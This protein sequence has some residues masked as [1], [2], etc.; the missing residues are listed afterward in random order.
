M[1]KYFKS[2]RPLIM[3]QNGAVA[4]NHPQA[5]LVGMDVLRS[6]GNAADAAVAVSLALGVV[7]PCMSGLGGDGFYHVWNAKKKHSTVFNGTGPAPKNSSK[8]DF[9]KT[10]V[11]VEG[12]LSI[13]TPGMVGG[14]SAMHRAEGT[15]SWRKV[16]QPAAN[17]A[18][19][20]FFATHAYR[21]FVSASQKKLERDPTSRNIFLENDEIP[22]LGNRVIQ[23]KLAMTLSSLAVEGAEGFYRGNLAKN[24]AEDMR[25]AKLIVTGDDLSSFQPQIQDSISINYRG[26][27]IKQTPPNSTGFT[28]LQ[29]LKI[30]EQFDLSNI[31]FES[32]ELIHL[33]VEAKKQAFFDRERFGSDPLYVDIP[34]DEL[35]SNSY[36]SE[37]AK[38]ICLEKSTTVPLAEIN[39][40]NGDTTYFCI[41]DRE[42]NAVSA[43]QSIN[44]VFGSGIT[45]SKTG[46]LFNNR[47][48]YWHLDEAHNNVLL[49]GKR[50]RHTMNAPIVLRDGNLW[51]VFGTPGADN[52]VQVNF[53]IAVAMMDYGLDPQQAVEAARWSSSQ[54]GQGANWPHNGDNSLTIE[55]GLPASTVPNLQ[56][57]G[58]KIQLIEKLDGPCSVACI[59]MLKNNTLIAGSDPRRDGWAG[60]Y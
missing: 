10:G 56:R 25:I 9:L 57:R 44:S 21:S 42:G 34:I 22:E 50:V 36:A 53:Q 24:I 47:M 45:G 17:L 8:D 14:L 3:G 29:E 32:A 55:K 11:A 60:A 20:G 33:M 51:G 58:H 13:S 59:R 27:E 54:I 46:I 16:C 6:G 2:Y 49:P 30:L 4:T 35:L 28:M 52:Q 40:L 5:T 15:L 48:A 23:P 41:V 43:I 7:E 19:K 38:K 26:F 1:T 31:A 39:S 37:L 12:R 18:D